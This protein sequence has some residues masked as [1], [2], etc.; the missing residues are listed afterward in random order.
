MPTNNSPHFASYYKI[1]MKLHTRPIEIWYFRWPPWITFKCH[2]SYTLIS[3]KWQQHNFVFQQVIVDIA[4]I[5]VVLIFIPNTSNLLL[6]NEWNSVSAN[7]SKCV[8]FTSL[9]YLH[10]GPI[11][12]VVFVSD[13]GY[14]RKTSILAPP[15]RHKISFFF[16]LQTEVDL[17]PTI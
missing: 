9:E 13:G 17:L 8:Y 4:T 5:V 12:F 2:Y 10:I 14:F 3:S 6:P 1:L 7:S 11:G 16:T 15:M